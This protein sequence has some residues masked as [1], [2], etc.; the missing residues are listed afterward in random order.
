MTNGRHTLAASVVSEKQLDPGRVVTR[1]L[2]G[3][4]TTP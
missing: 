1:L 3:M 4:G 2:R